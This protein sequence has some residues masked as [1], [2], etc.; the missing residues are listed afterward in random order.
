MRRIVVVSV[1]A[2]ASV[3]G[4]QDTRTVVEPHIPA[5]C[6]TLTATLVPVAD[7]T[8]ADADERKLD[9]RR[10]QQAIDGCAVG[11]AVVL[12]ANGLAR[13]F[14]AGPIQLKRGVTVVV[15]TNAILFASRD[16]REYDLEPGRCGTVD[17]KGHACKPLF[18]AERANGA[19]VMGPG[20]I[21]GRGWAKLLGKDVSWWDLAQEAKVKNQNQSCPRLMQLNRSDDF[22]L[23]RITLKNSP[24]FHVVF[25]R[26]NGFTAWGVVINTADKRA[27]NTDGIDPASATNVTITHSYI[28]TGDD[29]VAIKAGNTGPSSNITISHNHFYRGHGIS[30][31]S[32]T[33]GGAHAIRVF[34]LSID[35]ADNGL[36]IKSNAS[37]GGLVQDI[38]YKDVCIRNTKNVI[39]M[40]THY[41]ASAQTTG[42]L[43]PEFRDIRLKG[44]RVMDGGNVILDGYDAA[45]P[46]RMSWDDVYFDTP[47]AIK[48]KASFATIA[49]GPGPSNL[50]ITGERVAVTGA[51]SDAPRLECERKFV[52]FPGSAAAVPVGGGDYA[53]VVD[54]RFTG[55]DGAVVAGSPTYRTIGGALTALPANGAARAIVFIR[56]GRYREK[57]TVDRPRVTLLGES[58]DGAVMTYDAAS[59]TPT[60]TGGAYGTRGS[61]TLR[62]VAPD[63]RAENMA[64]EN[65]FDYPANAAKPDSDRSK[66]KNPQAVALM[67]DLG[68]DRAVFANVKL[69]GYQDTLFPNSGRSYFYKC[70]VWGHVDFIFGAGQAVFDDC[71]IISR[72]RGSQ[73]NNG[74]ITAP[75]TKADHQ[76]GFL[77]VHSRLKKERSDMAP[78]SVALGRPW[79]PFAD[80]GVN[81]AVAF[82]DCWMDDHI[83]ARGWDRMSSVDSTGTRTWY[84]PSN[85]RFYEFGTTGPGAVASAARRVLSANDAQRYTPS[86][87]LD[88]W[89]PTFPP[90]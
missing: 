45:R 13:A 2:I 78:N 63:F 9:T 71:D 17:E 81:S 22:T 15:D 64:I 85:A 76:F 61:Y 26:G 19:G 24:N 60:P 11:H 30:I 41:T 74:Y 87:V 69:T 25:D 67:T 6:A 33:D 27:R 47:N 75:S 42:K 79:H 44:V 20:T 8:L 83:G 12:K 84:E 46:L 57:L 28:N 73:T 82:V 31:G 65:A 14:L 23:Y 16:P 56:N 90:R 53:A 37:R 49:R 21:D 18:T 58:R 29:D 62:I 32:E 39:E 43:I 3:A 80:G 55:T 1:L 5:P 70:E 36:R 89:L 68:S 72:D 77:F 38:E 59:D 86:N 52:P 10:I 7:T 88:G 51:T 48:V 66:F 34:D 54:A 40:D 35:G 50:A 4:A